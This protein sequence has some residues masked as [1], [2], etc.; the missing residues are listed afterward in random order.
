MANLKSS[1]KDIRRIEKRT[2]ANKQARSRLKTLRRRADEAAGAD[3]PAKAKTAVS[4]LSSALDRAAK[5][6]VVH[7]NKVARLKSRYARH[8]AKSA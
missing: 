4:S 1:K 7:P 2:A 6:K 5:N 8:L 3:D